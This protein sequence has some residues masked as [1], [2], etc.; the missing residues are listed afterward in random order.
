[1]R[2]FLLLVTLTAALA[3]S[4]RA[5]IPFDNNRNQGVGVTV[6]MASGAGISY[7]EILPSALGYRAA[8]LAWKTGDSSFFDIGVSGLRV[9]SDDGRRR[10]YL[11]ASMAW[12]RRSDEETEVEFDDEGNLISERVFDD[13][14]DSGALGAGAGIE[15]PLGQS[16][17]VS[18]EA[19]FT[20][21]T[22]SGDLIPAPQASLHWLF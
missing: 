2:S 3:V 19:V 20:Y 4:A 8:V 21:W 9:L 17:A 12:W 16:A 10:I 22:D 15:L 14:D 18:L 1:M 13:V 11:L 6:G 7:Q 5:Q